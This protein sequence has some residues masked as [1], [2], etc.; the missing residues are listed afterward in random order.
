MIEYSSSLAAWDVS[1]DS[2]VDG[3]ETVFKTEAPTFFGAVFEIKR[4]GWSLW[5]GRDGVWQHECPICV[6]EA[7]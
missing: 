6:T 2:C 4:R 7:E 5:K 3:H 1:C